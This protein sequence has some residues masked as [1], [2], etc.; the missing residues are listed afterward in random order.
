MY[1]SWTL[2]WHLIQSIEMHFII[3]YISMAYR[4]I[5]EYF[6]K[7]LYKNTNSCVWYRE[8]VSESFECELGLKQGCL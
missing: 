3:N 2:R 4:E 1:F 8:G 6:K 7:C 5:Y